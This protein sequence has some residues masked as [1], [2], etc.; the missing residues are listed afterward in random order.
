MPV[1]RT[2]ARYSI[3]LDGN[4]YVEDVAC[5]F[6]FEITVS[7]LEPY[8][9]GQSRG[10]EVDIEATLTS[11]ALGNLTI[12]RDQAALMFGEEAIERA[13]RA[14]EDRMMEEGPGEIAA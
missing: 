7:P 14:A 12:T 6:D 11:V 3:D 13:E 4:V 8:S 5:D 2:C 1:T 9:W 10:N